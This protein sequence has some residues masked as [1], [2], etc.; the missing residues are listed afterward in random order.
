MQD[1]TPAARLQPQQIPQATD[2][3]S[4]GAAYGVSKCVFKTVS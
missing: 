4:S 3:N 1:E 2:E